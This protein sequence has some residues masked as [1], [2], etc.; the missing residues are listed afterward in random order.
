MAS[1]NSALM[2][3]PSVSDRLPAPLSLCVGLAAASV[4]LGD[5]VRQHG[6]DRHV[7]IAKTAR[8]FKIDRGFTSVAQSGIDID[9]RPPPMGSGRRSL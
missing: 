2:R 4:L 5:I 3:A 1:F 6:A 8:V 7:V 9:A